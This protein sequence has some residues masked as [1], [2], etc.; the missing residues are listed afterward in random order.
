MWY[1][2]AEKPS[3]PFFEKIFSRAARASSVYS[4]LFSVI[5]MKQSK[6]SNW[7]PLQM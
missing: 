3:F 1:L 4:Y 7:I 5:E 6:K 2:L